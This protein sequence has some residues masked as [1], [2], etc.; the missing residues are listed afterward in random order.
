[1]LLLFEQGSAVCEVRR[2][3]GYILCRDTC[4]EEAMV[5]NSP[6]FAGASSSRNLHNGLIS[7]LF[8]CWHRQLSWPFTVDGETYRVCL[9]CGA[10]RQFKPDVWMTVGGYYHENAPNPHRRAVRQE[11]HA[12]TRPEFRI[13]GIKRSGQMS[14]LFRG[15]RNSFVALVQ[16]R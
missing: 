7:R 1:M 13:A 11:R 5:I 10:R 8:G 4:E 9:R 6:K 14:T 12:G 3:T 2:C 16:G 15:L